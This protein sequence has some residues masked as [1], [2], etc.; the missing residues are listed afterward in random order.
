MVIHEKVGAIKIY[1]FGVEP[2]YTTWTDVV[3]KSAM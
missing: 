1:V 3:D 2:N